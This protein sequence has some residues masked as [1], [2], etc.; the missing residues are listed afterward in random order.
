MTQPIPQ[1]IKSSIDYWWLPLITG[2]IL[3]I[4]GIWVSAK[5]VEAY[6]SLS[7]LFG[8][9]ILITGFFEV[10]Y[11][12]TARKAIDGWG[13]ALASGL[14]D[15]VVGVFLCVHPML[16]LVILPVIMGFWLLFRG[17]VA[18]GVA[19]EM[20][21]FSA[22]YWGVLLVLGIVI[23]LFGGAVLMMPVIG[24]INIVVFTALSF[25]TAGS[26]RIVHA[27]RLRQLSRSAP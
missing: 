12:L 16:T 22:R 26:F 7:A 10:L 23:S 14:F 17:I 1:K 18:I 27:F 3:L 8:I 13:W 25:I 15:L 9:G 6:A 4:I 5:P 11:A 21:S 20:R 19:L 2:L 24:V